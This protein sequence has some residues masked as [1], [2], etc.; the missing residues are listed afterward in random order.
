MLIGKNFLNWKEKILLTLECMDL[1][2]A[3]RIDEPPIPT[4][5]ST[6]AERTSYEQWERSNHLSSI[7]IKSHVGKVF[8]GS[9]PKCTKAKDFINAV[10]QQTLCDF[11]KGTTQ[12]LNEQIIIHEDCQ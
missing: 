4:E 5:S 9:K 10:E 3:L 2:L 1:D 12:H 6:S 11:R 7:L 8:R